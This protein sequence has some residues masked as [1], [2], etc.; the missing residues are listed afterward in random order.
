MRPCD[1]RST[2]R[3]N[4]RIWS[5]AG[6]PG[7]SSVPTRRTTGFAPA[8]GDPPGGGLA[9][10]VASPAAPADRLGALAGFVVAPAAAATTG[11]QQGGGEGDDDWLHGAHSFGRDR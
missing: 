1:S 8:R 2:L 4:A 5:A 6:L 3:A 10:P 11:H 9:A 7:S